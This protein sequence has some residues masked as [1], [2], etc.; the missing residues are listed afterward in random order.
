MQF[1]DIHNVLRLVILLALI[2]ISAGSTIPSFCPRNSSATIGQHY[3]V[4]IYDLRSGDNSTKSSTPYRNCAEGAQCNITSTVGPCDSFQSKSGDSIDIQIPVGNTTYLY[5]GSN[6]NQRDCLIQFQ[7]ETFIN[8]STYIYT[9]NGCIKDDYVLDCLKYE[10]CGSCAQD[11]RCGWCDGTCRSGDQSGPHG[12]TCNSWGYSV[13]SCCKYFTDCQTCTNTSYGCGF[14]YGVGCF[15]GSLSGPSNSSSYCPKWN[16]NSTCVNYYSPEALMDTPVVNGKAKMTSRGEAEKYHVKQAIN[17]IHPVAGT[18]I[19]LWNRTGW[20]YS[21]TS[22]VNIGKM[23]PGWDNTTTPSNDQVKQWLE[24]VDDLGA[25][26]IKVYSLQTP[27]FYQILAQWNEGKLNPIRFIQVIEP[28]TVWPTTGGYDIISDTQGMKQF[29]QIILNTV[30]GVFGTT[31]SYTVNVAPYLYGWILGTRWNST[32]IS[33]TNKS[34]NSLDST[35]DFIVASQ[36]ATLFEVWVASVCNAIANAEQ[37]PIGVSSSMDQD[38]LEHVVMTS[39][40]PASF[41]ANHILPTSSWLA[42]VFAT[43]TITPAYPTSTVTE[44]NTC[45]DCRGSMDPLSGYLYTL[46]NYYSNIPILINGIG[47]ST[48][49]HPARVGV[50]GRDEGGMSE[51]SQGQFIEDAMHRIYLEGYTGLIIDSLFD[52]WSR[53]SWNVRPISLTTNANRWKNPLNAA[54]Y[55]GLIAMEAGNPP[56]AAQNPKIVIDGGESDWAGIAALN[57]DSAELKYTYDEEYLYLLFATADQSANHDFAFQVSN[58]GSTE[59][60]S[61]APNAKFGMRVDTYLSMTPTNNATMLINVAL[62]PFLAKYWALIN[63]TALTVTNTKFNPY[64]EIG[65]LN[66]AVGCTAYPISPVTAG[67]LLNGTSATDSPQYDNRAMYTKAGFVTEMRVPWQLL[68][69]MD[70]SSLTLWSYFSYTLNN[71]I[72]PTPFSLANI[73]LQIV[74][75]PSQSV[76]PSKPLALSVQGWT[77]VN[78]YPRKKQSWTTVQT[79]INYFYRTPPVIQC[80]SRNGS[81]MLGNL[82]K[83][84]TAGRL[85]TSVVDANQFNTT[86]AQF[87]FL[88]GTPCVAAVAVVVPFVLFGIG[89]A[90]LWL[91]MTRTKRT[92]V[93]DMLTAFGNSQHTQRRCP[94][95]RITSKT[96]AQYT[97][98]TSCGYPFTN[99]GFFKP[100]WP[101]EGFLT[102]N[103]GNIETLVVVY[104]NCSIL[105]FQVISRKARNM[106]RQ[107][108]KNSSGLG[109]ALVKDRFSHVANV[110]NYNPEVAGMYSSNV[111]EKKERAKA[112]QSITEMSDFNEWLH[113][114]EAQ[115][116]DFTAE[117]QNIVVITG[118]VAVQHVEA[119]EEQVELQRQNWN[120]IGI[121]R[122]PHWDVSTTADELKAMERASFLEWRRGLAEIEDKKNLLLTP[123]EKNIEVWRQLWRVV[124]RCDLIVQIVD[125]RN[126]LLFRCPDLEL[127]VKEI[128]T[129]KRNLLLVNKAD[130]LT[131]GQRQ[132]WAKYFRESGIRHAFFSANFEQMKI[133]QSELEKQKQLGNT[134]DTDE[135]QLVMALQKKYLPLDGQRENLKLN[136]SPMKKEKEEKEEEEEIVDEGPDEEVSEGEEGE[137]SEGEE[138]EEKMEL[139]DSIP[140]YEEDED[141]SRILNREELLAYLQQYHEPSEAGQRV[142]IG[143]VGYPNVG[144]SSTINVLAGEKKVAVAAQPGKTKHFQTINI[145]EDICLCDCPGLVYPTFASTKADMVCN[146]LLS[147][148]HMRDYRSPAALVCRRIPRHILEQAYGIV[149][150][151]PTS[152][153]P[154][155]RPATAEELLLAHAFIRGYMTVHGTPN[156]SMSARVVLKD[157]YNGRLVYVHPP[158]GMD[159]AKFNQH[160]IMSTKNFQIEYLPEESGGLKSETEG[161]QKKKNNRNSSEPTIKQ[162]ANELDSFFLRQEQVSAYTKGGKKD[163]KKQGVYSRTKFSHS[164]IPVGALKN[165]MSSSPSPNP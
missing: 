49:A 58:L 8:G 132:K 151:K 44:F 133:E 150:P 122:R 119:T 19:Q 98:T 153:E 2:S 148:D 139:F 59:Q 100:T 127:Y 74:N 118:P 24:W 144:K 69:F 90:I 28:N 3:T 106:G 33:L 78:Y 21:F 135:R 101:G 103:E 63:R 140:V 105:G 114:A 149:L 146:G 117:K 142:Q 42:G 131:K 165:I 41:D 39:E 66:Y 99:D 38:P 10:D 54:S 65:R 84:C 155:D 157:Y 108:K 85:N 48:S 123:F 1:D 72:L 81:C 164:P 30:D 160:N 86:S 71:A 51:T 9:S 116:R 35:G 15:D 12:T 16:F 120:S 64:R 27:S 37:H 13:Q 7:N 70:P 61:P 95:S 53:I 104:S 6:S 83:F 14:C 128:N 161:V 92:K 5:L 163:H 115:Q 93:E 137:V 56:D 130:L 97:H 158:P 136:K 107:K 23:L 11:S 46:R 143:M 126:P 112:M 55:F 129:N 152:E 77:N 156:E 32:T 60:L 121:P 76:S 134:L 31:G 89:G 18:Q 43:M 113:N 50:S 87:Q 40:H 45:I 29:Q 26:V 20:E 162:N 73:G 88:C 138:G 91:I 47:F 145:G 34:P 57:Y 79:A 67:V 94:T 25:R 22:G 68:G 125:A 4:V 17:M 52:E 159:G 154:A 147:I 102:V 124:E 82:P 109:R 75:Q 80:V 110:K 141:E 62:D 111:D 96:T 36:S